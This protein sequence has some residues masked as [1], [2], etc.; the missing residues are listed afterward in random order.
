MRVCLNVLLL[1]LLAK[2]CACAKSLVNDL[3]SS[4]RLCAYSPQHA[5]A[6][7]HN[8]YITFIRICI[9]C[10]S[11]VHI[12]INISIFRLLDEK[13]KLRYS[14]AAT[15]GGAAVG[16]RYRQVAY[17]TPPLHRPPTDYLSRA[18]CVADNRHL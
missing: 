8:R 5:L 15:V 12:Y 4:I 18:Q 7:A 16:P 6:R 17:R 14:A 11:I 3:V 13:K 1:L 10:K 2:R 9:L